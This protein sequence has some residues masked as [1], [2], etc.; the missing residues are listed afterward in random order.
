MEAAASA[1]ATTADATATTQDS[2]CQL[3]G[4]NL[5]RESQCLDDWRLQLLELLPAAQLQL[6]Q[7]QACSCQ[8]VSKSSHAMLSLLTMLQM[9]S[10]SKFNRRSSQQSLSAHLPLPHCT[11][12]PFCDPLL[13]ANLCG[14]RDNLMHRPLLLCLHYGSYL[15]VKPQVKL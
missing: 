7:P 1:A 4:A 2:F 9:L 10:G 8:F 12:Y 15:L 6:T 5:W 14:C 11:S 3:F 13:Y